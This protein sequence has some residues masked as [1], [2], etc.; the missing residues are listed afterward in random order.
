[1]SAFAEIEELAR[2]KADFRYFC[3]KYLWIVTKK[4]KR[5]PLIP[6]H[7]QR[8]VLD[9]LMRHNWLYFLKARQLG[10]STLIA[11]WFFWR[12]FLNQ[13]VKAAVIAH[14]LDT[15]NWI[16][17]IYQTYYQHLPGWMKGLIPTKRANE[18]ELV[19]AH[20]G[21]IK[22]TSQS[23]LGG[24]FQ[25]IHASE[26][27]EY[28][29]I[30]GAAKHLFQMAGPD[31][32][33]VIE[34]TAKGM[35]EAYYL[36]EDAEQDDMPEAS[37]HRRFLWWGLD[38]DYVGRPI[39]D[40]DLTD[41]EREYKEE[42]GLSPER[43]GW[44]RHILRKKCLGDVNL[45]NQQ[46]PAS[47]QLAFITSGQPYFTT[48]FYDVMLP[49]TT[50]PLLRYGECNEWGAYVLGVDTAGGSTAKETDFH[51]SVLVDATNRDLMHVAATLHMKGPIME[52]AAQVL[53]L[54][55]EFGALVVVERNSY[56]ETVLDYLQDHGYVWLYRRRVFDNLGSQWVEK[57]GWDTTKTTRP[58]MLAHMQYAL[59]YGKLHVDCPRLQ[60]EC[61]SFVYNDKAKAE[62]AQGQHDDLVV[63]CALALQGIE[64]IPG[65]REYIQKARRP[66]GNRAILEWELKTGRLYDPND[67][68]G[69]DEYE[70]AVLP[71]PTLLELQAGP[72]L[73]P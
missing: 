17:G 41:W 63:G 20:G 21:M 36:W 19:F 27:A 4:A 64:Q 43:M 15:A 26:F 54:A 68:F 42:F 28:R 53:A 38:D 14:T 52:Y 51:A 37:Y 49:K 30:K 73:A 22:V 61:N 65:V 56:G 12:C 55:E 46:Y 47:P 57:L 35:N 6:N 69:D 48:R 72:P 23:F 24:T 31:A 58:R 7:A 5:I 13:D 60:S 44:V 67:A 16:F 71:G 50:D 3:T 2:C 45:F 40:K 18:R 33:V 32:Q 25:H 9:D 1:M 62:A 34:T 66:V 8:I 10:A 39:K 29:D 11:A 59:A 70:P